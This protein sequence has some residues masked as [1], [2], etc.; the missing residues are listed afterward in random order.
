MQTN[1]KIG[2]IGGSGFYTLLKE[3]KLV[4]SENR[5]GKPSSPLAMGKLG[6]SSVAFMQRHG[7]KHTI[8]PHKVP[9]RANIEALAGAGV[10][11]IIATGAMGSLT[12]EYAPG[13]FVFLDQFVNMTH[14]RYDTFFDEDRVVHVSTA[15]PYCPELRELAIRE[16]KKMGVSFHET[17][18]IVVINGP[19]Y[20]TRA[21]SRF[22]ASQGFQ[23]IN[24]T[25]Y[26]EV[27]LAR[28]KAICYLGIGIV[29][30]YDA[31]LEG[32][33][34][35]KPVDSTEMLRVFNQNIEKVKELITRIVPAIPEKRSCPCAQ[36]LEDAGLS[37]K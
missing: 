22:F 30:D 35:I 2:I 16:A 24:M 1:A 8:P 19:R 18:T 37:K 4:E 5:Y 28:E 12:K 6:N 33:P 20:S 34:S 29:T 14:G 11:R 27:A 32:N 10:N 25:Q 23:V 26:P 7:E 21:E 3:P 31:G 15:H 9:Y 13:D 17:G 36:A